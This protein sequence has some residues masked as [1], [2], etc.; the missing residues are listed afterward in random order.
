M[1]INPRKMNTVHIHLYCMTYD[2]SVKNENGLVLL[3]KTRP[4]TLYFLLN[5]IIN[6]DVATCM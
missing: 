5:N 2:F 4:D 6:T 3:R 1:K